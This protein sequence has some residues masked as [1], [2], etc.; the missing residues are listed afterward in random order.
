MET[1][2]FKAIEKRKK[3]RKNN[4][5]LLKLKILIS[6]DITHLNK[7]VLTRRLSEDV[8]SLKG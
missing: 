8:T 3:K 5:I 6:E 1:S 2:K 4:N 7:T